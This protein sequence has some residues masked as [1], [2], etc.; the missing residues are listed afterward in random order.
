[1][2]E[3]GMGR[4]L[5][6][7]M[8]VSGQHGD[9]PELR[10]ISIELVRPGEHQPRR[11]FDQDALEALA[12]S[13]AEQGVL[14]PVLVR[15][16]AGGHYELVAGERRW[17]AAKL[18][19][20][21]VIPAIIERRDD[22]ASLEAAIVENMARA[23]LNPVEEARAVAALTEEL[24]LTRE[25]A[26][27]RVGRGR[28]AISNLLRIL[29]L[30][31]EA[32]ALLEDG[33]LTEGHGR[34]LLLAQDHADRRSLARDAAAGGWSVRVLEDR[35]RAAN[36]RESASAKR[37]AKAMHPDQERACEEIAEALAAAFGRDV[38]VRPKGTGYRVQLEVSD[39]DDAAA[40]ARTTRLTAVR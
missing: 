32:L 11:R 30:P 23:D 13:I 14:Q 19:G 26:G 33:S 24:G 15:P 12:G 1:M 3:R 7:I 40:L 17:R 35:A 38:V 20:L 29:D 27:K 34:A 21:P 36:E 10:D 16:L 6:A 22:A 37:A 18:A 5:A 25:E 39:A 28:V 2:A 31:D 4:G 8:Q 9:R